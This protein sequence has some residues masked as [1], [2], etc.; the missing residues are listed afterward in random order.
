[1]FQYIAFS[2]VIFITGYVFSDGNILN[3]DDIL[4]T[5]W[6]LF[7]KINYNFLVKIFNWIDK[8]VFIHSYTF[9]LRYYKSF[10]N[11][12]NTYLTTPLINKLYGS[13]SNE[14]N[15]MIVDEDSFKITQFITSFV[16]IYCIIKKKLTLFVV[17]IGVCFYILLLLKNYFTKV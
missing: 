5:F 6:S 14:N 7:W 9:S 2:Y 1:M 13:I 16:V 12:T 4:N 15:Y 8:L 17:K 10:H 11:F 3:S